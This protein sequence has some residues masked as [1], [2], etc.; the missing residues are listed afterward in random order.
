MVEKP[1]IVALFGSRVI[2]GQERANIEALA[3]LRAQGCAVLC[4]TRSEE[5]PE[6]RDLQ[7]RLTARDLQWTSVPHI[8]IPRRGWIMQVVA[9]NPFA[10]VLGNIKVFKTLRAFRATHIHLFNQF[11]ALNFAPAISLSSLKVIY[12]IGDTPALHNLVYRY[13]WHLVRRIATHFVADSQFIRSEMLKAGADAS[14]ISVLYAPPPTRLDREPVTLP[15]EARRDGSFRF[16]YV[17][18]LRAEKG[19]G[20]LLETFARLSERFPHAILLIAGPVPNWSGDRWAHD[21]RRMNDLDA[22]L[23]ERVHF[24]GAIENV[25]DLLGQCHVHVCPTLNEEPYGLVVVEAKSAGLPS[26]VFPS[27]GL[28][29]LVE[30]DVD[31]IVT[32]A[33]S[34]EDLQSALLRYLTEPGLAEIHG[35]RARE[36]LGKLKLESFAARWMDVYTT[37]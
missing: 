4:V 12:R 5:W 25:P 7:E 30:H 15:D 32:S 18:Q 34:M 2:F 26:I 13:S 29:E 28:R 33:K 10:Y 22:T 27:G 35:R 21:L 6:L 37:K 23:K 9:R 20:V 31:G 14:K 16:V 36:S 8:D 17:G 3:A 11:Y 24:L 19:V 1:R